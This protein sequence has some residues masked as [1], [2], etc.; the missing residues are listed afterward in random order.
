MNLAELKEIVDKNYN[1][2]GN[3]PVRFINYED[4]W[5]IHAAAYGSYSYYG[6]ETENILF[7]T[8]NEEELREVKPK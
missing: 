3:I 8:D 6:V 2:Y 4:V 1:R 7:L 5:E